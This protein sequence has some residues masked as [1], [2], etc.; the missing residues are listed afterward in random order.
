MRIHHPLSPG[1]LI[2]RYQR[3]LVDVEL[4][5][6]ERA[7]ASGV[8]AL[9]YQAHVTPEEIRLTRRLPVVLE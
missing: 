1:R 6:S 8:E 7:A 2:R 3:F 9:A 5:S 4:D